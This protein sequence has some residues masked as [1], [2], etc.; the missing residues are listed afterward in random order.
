MTP[1]VTI[2]ARDVRAGDEV[3]VL[4]RG[5]VRTTEGTAFTL[6]DSLLSIADI[7]EARRV[8]KPYEQGE[9]VYWNGKP[10]PYIIGTIMGDDVLLLRDGKMSLAKMSR[11]SRTLGADPA[12]DARSR[13]N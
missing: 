2:D 4:V 11:I 1:M 3:E 13:T 5:R 8:D 9:T 10:E 6:D 7:I 12:Q